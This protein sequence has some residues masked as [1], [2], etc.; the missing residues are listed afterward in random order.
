VKKTCIFAF[1]AVVFIVLVGAL[2]IYWYVLPK[3]FGDSAFSD[4]IGT[5]AKNVSFTSWE[6]QAWDSVKNRV[7]V[8][9]VD[10]AFTGNRVLQWSSMRNSSSSDYYQ[11]SMEYLCFWEGQGANGEWEAVVSIYNSP[12]ST[13]DFVVEVARFTWHEIQVK[14]DGVV[15]ADFP[16]VY[17]DT[18]SP[19]Y[20]TF[21]VS[22]SD[23]EP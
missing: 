21:R 10:P 4:S 18:V 9:N 5:G 15:V 23:V 1:I 12:N 20:C 8:Y 17:N 13:S 22:A 11:K 2:V 16:Q 7:V 14:L 3:S 19:G 6:L